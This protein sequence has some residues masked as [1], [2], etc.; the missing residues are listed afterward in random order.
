[1]ALPRFQEAPVRETLRMPMEQ[2]KLEEGLFQF[3]SSDSEAVS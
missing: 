2:Q 1:M 3:S